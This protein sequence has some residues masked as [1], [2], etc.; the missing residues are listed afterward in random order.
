MIQAFH[1]SRSTRLAANLCAQVLDDPTL[2][3]LSVPLQQPKAQKPGDPQ[4][5][6]EG[7]D[8]QQLPVSFGYR[9]VWF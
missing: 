9:I 7:M 6:G 4:D 5:Q 1:G 8:N 2:L 3:A